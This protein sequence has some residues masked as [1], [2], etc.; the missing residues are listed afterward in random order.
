MGHGKCGRAWASA[1]RVAS[2]A[3]RAGL[4]LAG[5]E[6]R[7][8]AGAR[9]RTRRNG[10]CVRLGFSV[11]VA[12]VWQGQVTEGAAAEGLAALDA[13]LAAALCA[14]GEGRPP[15]PRPETPRPPHPHGLAKGD[16]RGEAAP[17]VR[18]QA[19][20]CG[21]QAAGIGLQAEQHDHA[22]DVV[23]RSARSQRSS[24]DA[25]GCRLRG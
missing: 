3:A 20:G 9:T 13:I 15:Q 6:L 21:L 17:R 1:G 24:D 12:L 14:G 4:L 8:P 18:L 5:W 10:R 11:A 2:R 16:D 22:R 19:A 25:V 7:L 23:E